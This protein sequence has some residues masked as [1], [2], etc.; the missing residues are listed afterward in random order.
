MMEMLCRSTPKW[1]AYLPPLPAG[2][3]YP[4]GLLVFHPLK[5]GKH[6][7]L[8]RGNFLPL[9]ICLWGT[10]KVNQTRVH[11]VSGRHVAF[12]H[13]SHSDVLHTKTTKG[14]KDNFTHKFLQ[15]SWCPQLSQ[16]KKFS[17]PFLFTAPAKSADW[18]FFCD[19]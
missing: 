19:D 11:S 14:K 18:D 2:Y 8:Q 6:K 10:A 17:H 16:P 1:L 5:Q 3:A 13:T 7:I 9:E 4:I 12:Q 15:V